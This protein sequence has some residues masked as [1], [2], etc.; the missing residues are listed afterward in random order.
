MRED[1]VVGQ[2]PVRDRNDE[3]GIGA[4]LIGMARQAYRLGGGD[5][6]GADHHRH[7]ARD[8][9]HQRFRGAAALLFG[10]RADGTGAAEQ[11]HAVCSGGNL[12]VRQAAQ[13][14]AIDRTSDVVGV[15]TKLVKP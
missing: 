12:L 1:L 10:E 15:S 8:V 13:A 3:N 11:G 4:D 14:V 5:R 6:A 2:E 9:I 7:A